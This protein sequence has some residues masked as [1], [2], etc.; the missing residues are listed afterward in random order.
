MKFSITNIFS[1][2]DQIQSFLQIWSNLLKKSLMENVIFL[3]SMSKHTPRE[4]TI[5]EGCCNYHITQYNEK[6]D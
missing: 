4:K 6:N 1:K 5:M 2:F 3:Y